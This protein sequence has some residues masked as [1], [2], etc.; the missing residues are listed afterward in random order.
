MEI[1]VRRPEDN[2]EHV[3]AREK[4]S[5]DP[6]LENQLNPVDF[7]MTSDHFFDSLDRGTILHKKTRFGVIFIDGLHLA[8][9]VDRDISN[10]LRY[11][12]QDGF[13]VLHD[14]NPPTEWHAREN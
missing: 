5:V 10:S 1:G 3:K 7:K 9:Q 6:C 12:A 14:C 4:Y 11:L 2:L 8:D 13:I